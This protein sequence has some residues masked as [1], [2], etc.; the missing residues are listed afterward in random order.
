MERTTRLSARAGYSVV[1][2]LIACVVGV[3]VL[4]SAMTLAVSTFRSMAGMQ[5]RDGIDRNARYVGMSLQRDLTETGVMIEA[6]AN[7]GT[8]AVWS[9]TVAILRVHF[10]TAEAPRYNL[11]NSNI[12]TP[13]AGICATFTCLDIASAGAPEIVAGDLLRYQLATSRRLLLVTSVQRVGA[14]YRINFL[15]VTRLLRHDAGVVG[16][17]TN[18]TNY[19]TAFVQK[20]SMV[21]YYRNGTQLMRAQ[22]LNV[23]DGR[24]VAVVMADGFTAF[25][26]TLTFTDGDELTQANGLDGDATNDYNQISGIR[27]RA[28]IRSETT[29]ARVNAG[30]FISRDFEWFVAPRNLIYERNR[31]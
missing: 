20:L 26:A 11:T 30:A 27:I 3:L 25:T 8:L 12:T 21:E 18:T 4:S 19:T 29:D 1:E 16:A 9:D 6:Q 22:S 23:A 28:T 17:L 31:I 14:A 13:N 24:P 7:F 5:L 10:V 15:N 2:L